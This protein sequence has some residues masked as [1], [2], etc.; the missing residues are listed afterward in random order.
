MT[1]L[2]FYQERLSPQLIEQCHQKGKRCFAYGD[3]TSDD[4]ARLA[5]WQIDGLIT[6]DPQSL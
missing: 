1:T 5:Q 2:V 4:R 6:D 3:R